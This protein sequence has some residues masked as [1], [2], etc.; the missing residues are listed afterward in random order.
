MKWITMQYKGFTFHINPKTVKLQMTKSISTAK[1]PFFKTDTQETGTLPCTVS[2]SGIL[3]GKD[4]GEQALRLAALFQQKGS[5]TLFAPSLPALR[6]YFQSLSIS[7][8]AESSALQYTVT[9][10]QDTGAK[11]PVYDFGYTFAKAGEN[12]F[13]IANRTGTPLET[14]V[15]AN[16]FAT[17][18]AVREGDKVWLR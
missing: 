6:M 15:A 7:N 8:D 17:L 16:D 3:T 18:F 14:V 1:H 9:F 13:D 4:A 12:L 5:A 11:Q 10:V 2:G